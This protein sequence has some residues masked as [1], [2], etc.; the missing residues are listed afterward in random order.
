MRCQWGSVPG[1]S[2]SR[3][4]RGPSAYARVESIGRLGEEANGDTLAWLCGQ[5]EVYDG[6]NI[7][8]V[9]TPFRCVEGDTIA[10]VAATTNKSSGICKAGIC[11][12]GIC[13]GGQYGGRE[14]AQDSL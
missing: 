12:A 6:Y 9:A 1:W 8:R 4:R 14:M 7:K 10:S 13:K 3:R 2:F 5:I 11:K